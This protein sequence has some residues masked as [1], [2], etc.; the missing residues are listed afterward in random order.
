MP[1]QLALVIFE[2]AGGVSGFIAGLETAAGTFGAEAV[3]CGFG[4]V[5]GFGDTGI[6]GC[7]GFD[8]IVGA[9]VFGVG[10]ATAAGFFKRGFAGTSG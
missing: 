1:I 8:S 4:V 2:A 6:A 5:V 9:A 10:S 3:G 7:D